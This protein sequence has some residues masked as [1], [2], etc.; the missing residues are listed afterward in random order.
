MTYYLKIK[1]RFLKS[2]YIK[3]IDIPKKH[4]FQTEEKHKLK[5]ENVS[6]FVLKFQA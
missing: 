2:E 6:F 1:F 4:H 5:I 3:Y